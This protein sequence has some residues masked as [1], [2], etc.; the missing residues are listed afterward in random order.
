[1]RA[2][3]CDSPF[4]SSKHIDWGLE[5]WGLVIS[6]IQAVLAAMRPTRYRT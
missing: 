3:Q 5:D 6:S 4:L 1:M 2:D